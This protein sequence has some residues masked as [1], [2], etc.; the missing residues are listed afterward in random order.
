MLPEGGGAASLLAYHALD[1]PLRWEKVRAGRLLTWHGSA[2]LY[3][4]PGRRCAG[5]RLERACCP[6][7]ASTA[8]CT[9]NRPG[10][11]AAAQR[12][13]GGLDAGPAGQPLVDVHN[14]L[15]EAPGSTSRDGA[16]GTACE[17]G[18]Q[19][20]GAGCA[21]CGPIGMCL[22]ARGAQSRAGSPARGSQRRRRSSKAAGAGRSRQAATRLA[23]RQGGCCCWC[24]EGL[25]PA[26]VMPGEG[27]AGGRESNNNSNKA[28]CRR[29]SCLQSIPPLQDTLQRALTVLHVYYSDAGPLGPWTPH[30]RNPILTDVRGARRRAAAVFLQKR[31]ACGRVGAQ[32]GGR[33]DHA[34]DNELLLLLPAAAAAAAAAVHVPACHARTH[35]ALAAW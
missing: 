16:P 4:S 33:G 32:H 2:R 15:G 23:G 27:A 6:E 12:L 9:C 22:P 28:G 29:P 14:A 17:N 13:V 19:A 1:F 18:R 11:G 25:E 21:L 34:G 10:A 3:T 26:G 8:S 31:H 7:R 5:R 35:A 24:R 20:A 30:E